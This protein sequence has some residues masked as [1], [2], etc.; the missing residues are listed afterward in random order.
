MRWRVITPG[1]SPEFFEGNIR[2][3]YITVIYFS[4]VEIGFVLDYP[5]SNRKH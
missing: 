3:E 4:V 5:R 1:I 2:G